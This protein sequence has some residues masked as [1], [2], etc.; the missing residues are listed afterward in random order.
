MAGGLQFALIVV[1]TSTSTGG[2]LGY[3]SNTNHSSKALDFV[4]LGGAFTSCPTSF[5]TWMLEASLIMNR[6][7]GR[8]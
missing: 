2:R 4:Q 6:W 3:T 7:E 8:A 1:W 5:K